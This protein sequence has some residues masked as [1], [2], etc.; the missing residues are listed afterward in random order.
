MRRDSAELVRILEVQTKSLSVHQLVIQ[1]DFTTLKD[2]IS[3][4]GINQLLL[5]ICIGIFSFFPKYGTYNSILS[6][7]GLEI[8]SS[9]QIKTLTINLYDY[10]CRRYE[11]M[12]KIIDQKFQ[13][14][15]IPFMN[16][17]L[18]F[19]WNGKSFSNK[20]NMEELERKYGELVLVCRDGYGVLS[21]GID[22]FVDLQES[23]NRLIL[24]I[25]DGLNKL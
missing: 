7:N 11:N 17:E 4:E 13:F 9:N 3:E 18:D 25:R 22:A 12:D 2:S 14:K 20:V 6:N 5:D 24:Q 16:R 15:L 23:M 8:I 19:F 1:S 10:E 21:H